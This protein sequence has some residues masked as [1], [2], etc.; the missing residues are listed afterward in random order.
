M[1][2]THIREQWAVPAEHDFSS[3]AR[4]IPVTVETELQSGWFTRE[5]H[6]LNV[7]V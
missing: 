3:G 2:E 6:L 5:L 4:V 7:Y 1:S